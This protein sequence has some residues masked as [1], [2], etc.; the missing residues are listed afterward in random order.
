MKVVRRHKRVAA[1]AVAMTIAFAGVAVAYWT[2]GG[3][4]NGSA[5]TG[6][7]AL[8]TV[9][10]TSIVGNLYP[11]G[12]AQTLSGNFDNPN[13]GSVL[14]AAVTAV[15]DP[16]FTAQADL[17]KPACTSADFVIGGSAPV[18]VQIPSGLG[19]GSWTGLTIAMTNAVTNQDNCKNV[20]VPIDYTSN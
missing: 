9:H 16:S 5:A 2:Q 6:T 3:S 7:T 10:Q 19:V 13:A 1:I 12:P 14:V 17:T 11:G 18:G 20:S 15:V 4:G 8:V